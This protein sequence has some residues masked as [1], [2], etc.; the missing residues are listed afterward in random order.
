MFKVCIIL[1]KKYSDDQV[2]NLMQTFLHTFLKAR[3]LAAKQHKVSKMHAL[4]L[5][6]KKKVYKFTAFNTH[7]HHGFKLNAPQ[8]ISCKIEII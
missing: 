4:H 2:Y 7:G 6:I 1:M 3:M 5:N 8:N